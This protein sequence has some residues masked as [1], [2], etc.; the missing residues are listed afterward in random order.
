MAV[1]FRGMSASETADLTRNMAQ[2]G[3]SMDLSDVPGPKVDKHSTGGIGDKVSLILAPLAAACGLKVPSM[4][5]RGLG[6]SGGTIDKLEAISGYKTELT[7]QEFK[8]VLRTVGCSI[9]SQ[10]KAVA[11]ADRILYGLRDV[12]ATV[13]CIPLIVSSVLSKKI[14]EGTRGLVLDIKVGSGAFM[15]TVT[16]AK[17]LA[18]ALT[19]VGNKSGLQV[20]AV[21][22]NMDQPLGTA[23]GNSLEI[24]ECVRV[25]ENRKFE[26]STSLSS[27]LKELSLHL[28]AQMLVIGGTV[29]SQAEGK[30][31]ALNALTNGQA[32]AK[33]RAMVEAHGGDTSQI[34]D[35]K[36]LPLASQRYELTAEESGYLVSMDCEAIGRMVV[37][38]GGGRMV[39]KDKIDPGVGMVFHRKLGSRVK[40]G[41]SI[42]TVFS[43]REDLKTEI[44]DRFREAVVIGPMRRSAPPLL[45]G[46]RS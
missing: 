23:V 22:S 7:E 29:R 20:Q 35:P 13:E 15:K 9:I 41:D 26:H 33:F 18:K 4:A 32:L 3:M 6:H 11:P 37:R 14:A 30:K 12:T 44:T 5:G 45:M 43:A 27:D 40:I 10:S 16:Q 31:K 38:M 1:F 17:K 8:H 39:A 24:F 34:D 36:Q 2:S 28:C 25:M 21:L 42:A 46:G 19:T